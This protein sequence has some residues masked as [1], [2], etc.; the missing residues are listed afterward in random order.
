MDHDNNR[1]TMGSNTETVVG[2]R[3]GGGEIVRSGEDARGCNEAVSDALVRDLLSKAPDNTSS[4]VSNTAGRDCGEETK[5]SEGSD[6]L[7]S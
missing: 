5:V 6:S 4:G 3:S 7:A 1:R 2:S